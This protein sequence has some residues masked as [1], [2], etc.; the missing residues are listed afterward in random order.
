MNNIFL[1]D[2]SAIIE[3]LKGNTVVVEKYK[4]FPV[5]TISLV[6]GEVYYFCIKTNLDNKKFKET[7]FEMVD[8]SKGD[9]ENAMEFLFK[10]KK[11][12]KDFS[13]IGAMLY[14]ITMKNKLILVTKD[15]GFKGL[16]DIEFII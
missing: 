16:K 2:S 7:N 11:E 9:I 5:I 6:Y 14:T 10:R 13:F 1:F 3:I 4:K 12:V 8:Y 15:F